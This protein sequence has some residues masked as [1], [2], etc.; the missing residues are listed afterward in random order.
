MIYVCGVALPL[1][2]ALARSDL[3]G[4]IGIPLYALL[5]WTGPFV[6]AAAVIWSDWSAVWRAVW[7]VLVPG[8]VAAA[9]GL[10]FFI[11]S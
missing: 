10:V 8:F 5:F 2:V 3:M 9:F 1:I 11:L 4:A 6:S 7:I